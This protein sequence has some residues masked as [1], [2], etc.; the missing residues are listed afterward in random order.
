[1]DEADPWPSELVGNWHHI[2]STRM[3]DDPKQGVVDADCRVHVMENLYLAGSS[4]FPVSASTSPTVAIVQLSLR[5]A[6]HLSNQL[7]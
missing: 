7:K 2:G 6:E 3:H 5:L 4:V 1:M